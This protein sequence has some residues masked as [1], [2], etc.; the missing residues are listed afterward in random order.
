MEIVAQRPSGHH[1]WIGL[2]AGVS[3]GKAW[4]PVEFPIPKGVVPT[5]LAWRAPFE[6]GDW[7]TIG[8]QAFRL[9]EEMPND[10]DAFAVHH[11]ADGFRYGTIRCIV[12]V[13]RPTLNDN[14]CIQFCV[15][16]P[17]PSQA[18]FVGSLTDPGHGHTI[19]EE[20]IQG[21]STVDLQVPHDPPL[22]VIETPNWFR[23]RFELSNVKHRDGNVSLT[24]RNLVS[25]PY[26]LV[27]S[28]IHIA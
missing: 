6:L 20:K 10:D 18:R 2:S 13:R 23:H 26:R 28:L 11:Y 15:R 16:H 9:D 19:I 25:R 5:R 3:T 24:V 12:D 8:D 14:T 1:R 7:I 21:C 22:S 4:T 17:G 27:L